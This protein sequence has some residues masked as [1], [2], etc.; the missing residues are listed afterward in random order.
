MMMK[1]IVENYC[2]WNC[3]F[4]HLKV[5]I[6]TSKKTMKVFLYAALSVC[7]KCAP[8]HTFYTLYVLSIYSCVFFHYSTRVVLVA[9]ISTKRQ[10][11]LQFCW[12]F[13]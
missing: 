9:A 8:L 6:W 4:C 11:Q 5:S 12:R 3:S 2:H 1:F 13:A 7:T 10:L